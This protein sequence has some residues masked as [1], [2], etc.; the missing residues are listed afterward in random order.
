MRDYAKVVPKF[1]TGETGKAIR[2]K[3]PEGVVVA[4][5]LMTSPHSNMLGLFYQPLLYMAHETGLGLEGA[6]KGLQTCI[7]EGFCRYD[8]AS[9]MVWVEEMAKFQIGS[10]LK[11]ADNRCA[12]IQKEYDALQDNPFLYEF[13]LRYHP[14]YHLSDARGYEFYEGPS[15]PL[16]SQEQ[17]QE[18]EQENQSSLRSDS[19][20]QLALTGDASPPADLKAR[21]AHRIQQISEQA[22]EAYNRLLAKPNGELAACAVLNKPRLKAVEKALPTCRAICLQLYGNER[23]TAAFWQALFETA[24]DDDFHAGRARGGPG[25]ENWKPDFEYLLRENVIAKLF[26]RAMSEAAA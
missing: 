17:E 6:T 12:G 22:Q 19:S 9:E 11:A 1:W 18:Q 5:Y 8:D 26:D 7:E 13:W 2:K 21:K 14:E 15:K 20:P 4:M 3:G 16:P 24:A 10:N 25:H 23:V